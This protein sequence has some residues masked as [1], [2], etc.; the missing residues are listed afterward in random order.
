MPRGELNDYVLLCGG[1]PTLSGTIHGLGLRKSTGVGWAKIIITP[2]APSSFTC[3]SDGNNPV[4]T[5]AASVREARSFMVESVIVNVT[6]S[7]SDLQQF[8][9]SD[10]V[11]DPISLLMMQALRLTLHKYHGFCMVPIPGVA[12]EHPAFVF[13]TYLGS[14]IALTTTS[15]SNQ[16]PGILYV[17]YLQGGLRERTFWRPTCFI[18]LTETPFMVP[19]GKP[20]DVAELQAVVKSAVLTFN[21]FNCDH[22]AHQIYDDDGAPVTTMVYSDADCPYS[23]G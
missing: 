13:T 14:Y 18:P 9:D 8:E 4:L 5:V 1:R 22:V 15:K 23:L 19:W 21:A 16:S 2:D 6:T 3:D 11:K 17:S 10:E 12:K 20:V 7:S